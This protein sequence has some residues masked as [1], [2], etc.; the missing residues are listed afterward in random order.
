VLHVPALER[1][2][3]TV[4][5]RHEVLRTTFSVFNGQPIQV[6]QADTYFNLKHIDVRGLEIEDALLTAQ[7]LSETDGRQ[8]FDLAHDLPLR[9]TLI[10]LNGNTHHLVLTLHHI[11]SDAW[12][13][14]I[15]IRELNALYAAFVAG[16]PSPLPEL[17]LQYA[18]F[19]AWQRE[20]LQGQI[21]E[22]EV[23]YWRE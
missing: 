9:A 20:W 16:A 3:R 7:R 12:S 18:D 11:V 19:A 23:R 13:N 1:S 17:P 22:E 6:I 4:I 8:L 5:S 14:S 21:L 15:Y 2:S 10:K